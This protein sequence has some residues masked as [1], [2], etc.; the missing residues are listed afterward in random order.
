M[1]FGREKQGRR[2]PAEFSLTHTMKFHRYAISHPL[3]YGFA[4]SHS[5]VRRRSYQ[6]IKLK[7]PCAQ[8]TFSKVSC[9]DILISVS[10]RF[11]KQPGVDRLRSP[12]ANSGTNKLPLPPSSARVGLLA[13]VTELLFICATQG[14]KHEDRY[15]EENVS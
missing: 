15:R 7:I 11:L 3:F 12:N 9:I 13:A 14:T 2:S 10:G 4:E 5:C 8:K 6:A 1:T